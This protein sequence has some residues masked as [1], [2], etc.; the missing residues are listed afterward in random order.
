MLG[1]DTRKINISI[2][3]E[4]MKG[5]LF[6]AFALFS[7]MN[8]VDACNYMFTSEHVAIQNTEKLLQELCDYGKFL[9]TNG[10]ELCAYNYF[11]EVVSYDTGR[12]PDVNDQYLHW[13]DAEP[14]E[15]PYIDQLGEAYYY[16]GKLYQHGI[17][18]FLPANLWQ[19]RFYFDRSDK[20]LY[21][22]AKWALEAIDNKIAQQQN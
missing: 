5:F 2:N 15:I 11:S 4:F 17:R 9:I 13:V 8:N 16:L 10:D 14:E 1:N 3:G 7:L 18:D 6:G 19:A 22:P 21:L 20:L 12:I